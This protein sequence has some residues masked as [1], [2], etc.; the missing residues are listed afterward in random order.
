[1]KGNEKESTRRKEQERKDNGRGPGQGE[2]LQGKKDSY[3]DSESQKAPQEGK[4]VYSDS[5][6]ESADRAEEASAA[7][8]ISQIQP[9]SENRAPGDA[10]WNNQVM[11]HGLVKGAFR[12]SHTMCG[13]S[14]WRCTLEV[15]RLSGQL[16]H[17]PFIVSERLMDTSQSYD[18]RYLEIQGQLRSHDRVVGSHR[19]L[20][21]MV[22]AREVW[23]VDEKTGLS[24][25]TEQIQLDG[26]LCRE[27]IYRATPFGRE[28]TELMLAVNRPYGKTDYIPC[29]CWGRNARYAGGFAVGF[30]LLVWGR[31][32][33]R[34]YTKLVEGKTRKVRRVYE[35]SVSRM[36]M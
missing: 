22:F 30:R 3:D 2:E 32:Q 16:D 26:F 31:I 4:A 28:I 25:Q 8:A 34:E 18:G 29:V 6:K 33:S 20:Q 13:E 12:Y 10:F 19:E 1:M 21:L 7:Y 17:I 36:E 11:I 24:N 23:E 9:F 14:F 27:P 15:R 5:G 35:V